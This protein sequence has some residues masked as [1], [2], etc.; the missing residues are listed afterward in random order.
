MAHKHAI[1]ET[2]PVEVLWCLQATHTYEI[3]L[4]VNL[5]CLT[6]E[7]MRQFLFI[8]DGI[9]Y[10]LQRIGCMECIAGIKE[11]EIVTRGKGN[12]LVHG[13]V[14]SVIRFT[15]DVCELNAA[16]LCLFNGGVG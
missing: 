3:A 10:G 8:L 15:H 13:I 11:A 2:A 7:Y 9:H 16:C 1:L 12:S 6:V 14:K 5:G 4:L